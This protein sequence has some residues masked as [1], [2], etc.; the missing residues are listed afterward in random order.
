VAI[1]TS[2]R[3][4]TGSR[5]QDIASYLEE[6]TG[7]HEAYPATAFRLIRCPCRSLEFRVARALA[8][9]RRVCAGCRR[10]KFICRSRADWEEARREERIAPYRCAGCGST[11]ANITVGFAAYDDPKV[12]A[13]KWYYVGLRC[14][15]CGVLCCFN[16]GKAG[17]GPARRV[18]RT[19]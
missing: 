3:W 4:W 11:K 5:P 18:Y 17:W 14:P 8:V 10:T 16:D 1:D 12:D 19:A 7:L 2:G 6:Y 9:T 15:R 13:V